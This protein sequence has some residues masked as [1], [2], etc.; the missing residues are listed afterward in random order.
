MR[1][2]GAVGEGSAKNRGERVS[3]LFL[4]AAAAIA[5]M[6]EAPPLIPLSVQRRI[7]GPSGED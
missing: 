4:I 1:R 3:P 7:P 6:T 2:T 5:A